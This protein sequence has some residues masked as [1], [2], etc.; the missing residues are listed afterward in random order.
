MADEFCNDHSGMCERTATLRAEL[1]GL[2][3]RVN[4]HLNNG[5][6]HHMGRREVERLV[7][8][9]RRGHEKE[10]RTVTECVEKL[11]ARVEGAERERRG[12]WSKVWST[13]GPPL[14]AAIVALTVAVAN[15]YWH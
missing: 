9:C 6:E 8:E 1:D 13:W 11:V 2:F 5:G 12:H 10:M 15:H 4:G 14:L 7:G 3:A